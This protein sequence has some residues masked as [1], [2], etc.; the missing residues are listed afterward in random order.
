MKNR[1]TYI[2]CAVAA[3]LA[4]ASVP[5]YPLG[6]SHIGSDA[7][8]LAMF[9]DTIFVAEGRIGDG[10]GAATFELDLGKSTSQPEVT[11][12][13]DWSNGMT[14]PFTLT[15]DNISNA[16][17]FT[18]GGSTLNWASPLSG[19]SDLFVRTRAVDAASDIVIQNLSL[20]GE[21]INDASHA[22]GANGLDILWIKGGT[23]YD[24]FTLSGQVTMTWTGTRPSQSRLA[25][26][27][28]VDKLIPT[29]V[30]DTSWGKI[31]SLYR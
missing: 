7:E 1:L 10:L 8:M 26:Q 13:F 30:S 25:F 3:L 4:V 20:D 29:G 9:S 24:G 21:V 23:I 18:V 27:I 14:V 17:V 19:Y 11:A 5:A 2:S 28:K 31:K 12:Q 6:T 22:V 15:Y 16:V